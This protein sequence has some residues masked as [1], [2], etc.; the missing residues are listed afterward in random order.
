[1]T[2]E[3]MKRN[4]QKT[5]AAYTEHRQTIRD[6]EEHIGKDLMDFSEEEKQMIPAGP[7]V[8]SF[9]AARHTLCVVEIAEGMTADEVRRIT[10]IPLFLDS[11]SPCKDIKDKYKLSWSELRE[12]RL[13]LQ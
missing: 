12:L 5:I 7:S 10:A 13:A 11:M 8:E 2:L 9:W 1:M 3:A 4:A 6:L